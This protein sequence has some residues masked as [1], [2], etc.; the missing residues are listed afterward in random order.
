M[1]GLSVLGQ[2]Q[3]LHSDAA[4]LDA[5]AFDARARDIRTAA[6]GTDLLLVG[7]AALA[8]AGGTMMVVGAL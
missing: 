3:A 1:R 8:I 6:Y 7:A 4:G 2:T 5:G